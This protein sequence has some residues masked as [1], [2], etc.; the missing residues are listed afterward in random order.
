MLSFV[1][2]AATLAATTL[3]LLLRPW[4]RREADSTVVDARDLAVRV[5][6]AQLAELD[7]D[8]AAGTLSPA[9]HA[10][11][12]AEL[13]R[14]L[15]EDAE[16]L[17]VTAALP[18]RG[19]TAWVLATA[20]PLSAAALYAALGTPAALAPPTEPASAAATSTMAG[21]TEVKQMLAD[22]QARA[23]Q[24]P[25]NSRD[26]ALL[27]RA[28]RL[29]G[30]LPESARAF[31]RI[32]PELQASPALLVEYADVLAALAQ[33]NLEGQPLRLVQQALA[34]DPNHVPALSLLATAASRRQD[35]A[36]AI[37]T[38]ERALALAP[39][40]SD[41]ATWLTQVLA[42]ARSGGLAGSP[43]SATPMA[44]AAPPAPVT[45]VKALEATA[46]TGRISLAPAL[47]AQV[48]PGD[49]L[50]V[51]ARPLDGGMPL[52][53]LRTEA[54]ALPLD[55]TLDDSR[56]MSPAARLSGATRVRVDARISRSGN[57]MPAPGDLIAET[58]EVA[59][60]ARR[61]SLQ[62]DR[63]RR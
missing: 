20:L 59:T 27:A 13:Q 32:G 44:A 17:E 35:M 52:A 25:G 18:S 54:S 60:G 3:L 61:L 16:G 9:D 40:G 19:R 43:A 48:Q 49:T 45:A 51:Y 57:A 26:W 38:W 34:L 37:G 6:R 62:I 42:E 14:R 22:L 63:V 23:E 29:L 2:A 11:A 39:P 1:L 30:R 12:A 21:P 31:E 7:R 28:Y 10:H 15:L 47:A 36:L 8:L 53:V 41:D 55:F 5:C 58:Q 46:I 24:N 56:A 33:G 4:R 50:F